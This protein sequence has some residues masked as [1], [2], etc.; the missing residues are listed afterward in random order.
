MT[1]QPVSILFADA[2]AWAVTALRAALALRSEAYKS[3]VVVATTVPPT[4]PA[5]LVTVRRDGGPARGIFD[6]P[7]FGVN[8]WAATDEDATDL[9]NLVAALMRR[10]PGD[11]TCVSIRQ[12]SGAS[13]VPDESGQPRRFCTFEATLR[14]GVLS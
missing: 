12:L 5:R 14:G 7:R 3:G 8:V 1:L 13:P 6:Y 2:E 9:A 10:L 4:R 11:G